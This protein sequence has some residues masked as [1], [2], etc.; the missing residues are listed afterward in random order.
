LS[1]LI[2]YFDKRGLVLFADP[3]EAARA[4]EIAEIRNII[5]HN[6]SIVNRIFKSRLP[7]YPADI[8][9]SIQI[10]M[11]KAAETIEFLMSSTLDIDTR[12][13]EKFHL[14][15]EDSMK[16]LDRILHPLTKPLLD[17][18]SDMEKK[19]KLLEAKLEETKQAY[20]AAKQRAE[21]QRQSE[22]RDWTESQE[23]SD[24]DINGPELV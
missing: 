15:Q 8:G 23:E 6:H 2:T 12:A 10:S 18:I 21:Q 14:E 5:V 17:E 16:S 1:D 11:Q 9:D 22:G 4:I 13:A 3:K 19:K 20:E 7:N 24:R